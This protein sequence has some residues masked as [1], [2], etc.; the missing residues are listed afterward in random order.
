[1]IVLRSTLA[2][3]L[4]VTTTACGKDSL[5]FLL[6]T[7]K[8]SAS[9]QS[10]TPES[11]KSEDHQEMPELHKAVRSGNEAYAE[12]L[13]RNNADVNKQ[14]GSGKTALHFAVLSDNLSMT[15]LLIQNGARTDIKD[16]QGKAPVDYWESGKNIEI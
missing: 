14:M 16:R 3:A 10:I 4:A 1:M 13:I 2:V 7:M 8:V 12:W 5:V 15:K 11:L 6:T 9:T